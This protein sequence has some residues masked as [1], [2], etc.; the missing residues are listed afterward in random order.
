MGRFDSMISKGV[1]TYDADATATD[2][3]MGKTAYVAGEKITGTAT[4][5]GGGDGDYS[6]LGTAIDVEAETTISKGSRIVC[7]ANDQY[8]QPTLAETNHGLSNVVAVSDDMTVIVNDP[9]TGS[10][11]TNAVTENYALEFYFLDE[12]TGLYDN[13]YTV[14]FTNYPVSYKSPNAVVFNEDATLAVSSMVETSVRS[15]GNACAIVFE[16]DKTNHAV[17][18]HYC[19]L[20]SV[21]IDANNTSNYTYI[22][23]IEVRGGTNNNTL[24]VS[25]GGVIGTDIYARCQLSVFNSSNDSFVSNQMSFAVLNYQSGSLSLKYVEKYA[26]PNQS[27]ISS[28]SILSNFRKID[29]DTVMFVHNGGEIMSCIYKYS[30][31]NKT[32]QYNYNLNNVSYKIG[33]SK[34]Y[35]YFVTTSYSSPNF[36]VEVFELNFVDLTLTSIKYKS[37]GGGISSQISNAFVNN[38]GSMVYIG[39]QGTLVDIDNE[40]FYR[41]SNSTTT[42]LLAT[43]YF[44]QNKFITDNKIRS[45]VP[46]TNAQYLASTANTS[47]CS[48]ANRIYGVASQN[49]AVGTR[50]YERGLFSTM[51]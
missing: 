9:Q 29:G 21:K 13:K 35:K 50:G 44:N 12:E 1:N 30:I 17:S 45:L 27:I 15:P 25:R 32:L 22:T 18:Y 48:T 7:R 31:S 26:S 4:P 11:N 51:T 28:R 34:N 10:V 3:M 2:I 24:G 49:L 16:I 5:G 47:D 36:R 20:P 8:V 14:T 19:T 41:V 33:C 39:Q 6:L 23:G 43:S 37:I 40:T 42:E 38:D 46:G